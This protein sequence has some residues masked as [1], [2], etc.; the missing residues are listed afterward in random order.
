MRAKQ[1]AENERRRIELEAAAA[2]AEADRQAANKEHRASV[3]REI[4]TALMGAG[5]SES[6]AKLVITLA[7]KC[8]AG[9]LLINY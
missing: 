1:A 6:D 3:N 8:Q 7:A 2:K 4:L 5:I 9:R